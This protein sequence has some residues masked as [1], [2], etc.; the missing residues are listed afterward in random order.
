MS[1]T[2]TQQFKI[3]VASAVGARDF[4]LVKKLYEQFGGYL[5]LTNAN[6]IKSFGVLA[7][8]IPHRP[9]IQLKECQDGNAQL[10]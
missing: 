5:E 8:F 9:M 3:K 2:V 10:H 6:G 7:V 4:A 1:L